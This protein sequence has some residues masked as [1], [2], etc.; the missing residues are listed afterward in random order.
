M[1]QGSALQQNIHNSLDLSTSRCVPSGSPRLSPWSRSRKFA[2]VS[3][4]FPWCF[5]L[6]M[7]FQ[8]SNSSIWLQPSNEEEQDD[9][10]HQGPLADPILEDAKD[11]THNQTHHR[12]KRKASSSG[13]TG[14]G[15]FLRT[16]CN[17]SDP[18]VYIYITIIIIHIQYI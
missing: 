15:S 1:P 5:P 10:I 17:S 7:E 8:V 18:Y 11:E 3:L 12:R 16:S 6:Y 4:V 13:D 9:V 14:H 2:A